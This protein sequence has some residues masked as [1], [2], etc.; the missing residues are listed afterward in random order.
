[1]SRHLPSPERQVMSHRDRPSESLAA[2]LRHRI[3]PGKRAPDRRLNQGSA[4]QPFAQRSPGGCSAPRPAAYGSATRPCTGPG[5]S[6]IPRTGDPPWRERAS[7]VPREVRSD[8][9][10]GT[11]PSLS[12]LLRGMARTTRIISR[13]V[14]LDARPRVSCAANL[15]ESHSNLSG[16]R[17]PLRKSSADTGRLPTRW[18]SVNSIAPVPQ[19]M[20]QFPR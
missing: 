16:T 12:R 2:G 3:L 18:T 4:C 14:A 6:G 20:R 8:F 1:M 7:A 15:R 9:P 11:F 13:P 5:A 10:S 17:M 19:A